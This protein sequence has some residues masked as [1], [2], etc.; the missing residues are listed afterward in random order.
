MRVPANAEVLLRL[1]VLGQVLIQHDLR[2]DLSPD[3]AAF[4][5][6]FGQADACFTDLETAIRSPLAEAPT[7]RRADAPT[8]EGVFL[9]V[10]DPV[11]LDCLQDL[12]ISLL[13]TANNHSWDLGTGGIIGKAARL[14]FADRADDPTS[15]E[16]PGVVGSSTRSA[17]SRR[18]ALPM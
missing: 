11:V 4:A 13:A 5:T 18:A 8:R 10:A 17:N 9:H 12:S 16:V 7:R 2:A 1:T 6:M 15:A 14:E 3:F